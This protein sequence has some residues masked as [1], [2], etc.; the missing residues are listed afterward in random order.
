MKFKWEW[1]L[2]TLEVVMV[3]VLIVVII[4][5]PTKPATGPFP[6]QASYP[7]ETKL[8]PTSA[9]NFKES[10]LPEDFS[11]AG[12]RINATSD[13]VYKT[14][15]EPIQRQ[16]WAGPEIKNF[17]HQLYW[18]S[19][20][21][22]GVSILFSNS[23][24]KGQPHTAAPGT[25]YRLKVT[26]RGLS[27]FRG[28]KIGDKLEKLFAVYGPNQLINGAYR[29]HSNGLIYLEFTEAKGRVSGIEIGI[30]YN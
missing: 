17:S 4:F 21:Y 16:A 2:V 12:I 6:T 18:E 20:E 19:W 22:S 25:V 7:P 28:I 29:Y 26:G 10:N 13:Q 1:L 5:I 14:L 15:G 24:L 8:I 30:E 23:E 9:L 3:G 27:T 11:F